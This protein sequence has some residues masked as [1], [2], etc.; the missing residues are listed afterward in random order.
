MAFTRS[1][2]RNASSARVERTKEPAKYVHK[3]TGKCKLDFQ[4]D[5]GGPLMINRK[6]VWFLIGTT[7]LGDNKP[8]QQDHFPG[9]E[10]GISEL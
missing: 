7:D 3:L 4:G 6:G 1:P 5:S 9:T 10:R 2:I 8:T